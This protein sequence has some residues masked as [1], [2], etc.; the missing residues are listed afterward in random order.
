MPHV[1]AIYRYPVKGLSPEPLDSV[2][3]TPGETLPYDRAYAIENGP[4]GFDPGDPRTLPKIFY[5]MLLRNESLAALQTR[6][7]EATSTLTI[8]HDGATV[9]EGNLGTPEGRGEIEKFFARYSA[10]DL[11]G[12]PRILHAPGFSFSDVAKKVV[13]LIN[14]ESARTL[15]REIGAEVSPLRFRGNLHVEGMDAWDEFALATRTFAIGS[16]TFEGVKRIERCAATN[17]DPVTAKRDLTIPVSLLRAYGHTDCGVY[18]RVVTGGTIAVG[19][20]LAIG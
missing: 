19:D 6:F 16:V 1:A 17:V 10:N 15:G 12:P 9:A 5:L 18:L 3:L 7:D 8:R 4:S 20:K 14:L 2:T 11:R 13:S